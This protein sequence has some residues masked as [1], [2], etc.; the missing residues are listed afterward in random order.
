MS[1]DYSLAA[2]QV[3][4]K[5]YLADQIDK[6]HLSLVSLLETVNQGEMELMLEQTPKTLREKV[7]YVKKVME[8][9]QSEELRMKL[10]EILDSGD[11]EFFDSK[12]FPDFL[13]AMQRRAEA[14]RV[15]KITV[16]IEFKDKDL[17]QMVST[18]STQLG[19]PVALEVTVDPTL[20]GG[21]IVRYGNYITDYS[22]R[23]R[24]TQFRS[25]WKQMSK[26]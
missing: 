20:I 26:Q 24:F 18:L 11:L 9:V 22:L 12:H 6:L 15:I 13:H 14:I 2:N 4:Q 10:L 5:F 17:H 8:Q 3:L 16:A 23:T 25:D 19:R 21:V 7:G 1:L